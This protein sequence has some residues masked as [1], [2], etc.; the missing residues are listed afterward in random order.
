MSSPKIF[1]NALNILKVGLLN[2]STC[3]V[4]PNTRKTWELVIL[5]NDL[6]YFVKISCFNN[7][8]HI[9]PKYFQNKP[10]L[11]N[12]EILFCGSRPRCVTFLKL[13]RHYKSKLL[14][15]STSSGILTRSSCLKKRIGGILLASL[16]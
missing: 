7:F 5:L 8:L 2:R 12:I 15:V 14:L 6:G 4:L 9:S 11:Q 3:I 16:N 13:R 10:V 1:I